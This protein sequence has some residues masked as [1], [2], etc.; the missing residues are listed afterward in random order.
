MGAQGGLRVG[1]GGS[2]VTKP[3]QAPNPA[4]TPSRHPRQREPRINPFKK[5]PDPFLV[6]GFA[7]HGDESHG[8]DRFL[9]EVLFGAGDSEEALIELADGDHEPAADF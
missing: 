8:E 6:L 7:G 9:V 1:V 3:N 5:V 4:T 2:D